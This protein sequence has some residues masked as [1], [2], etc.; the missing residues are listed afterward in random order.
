MPIKHIKLFCYGPITMNHSSPWEDVWITLFVGKR[1]RKTFAPCIISLSAL[2]SDIG[3]QKLL[4]SSQKSW[5]EKELETLQEVQNKL[6]TGYEFLDDYSSLGGCFNIY[7]NADVITKSVAQ[8]IIWKWLCK[9]ELVAFG[10]KP[11]FNWKMPK[12]IITPV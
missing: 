8:E 12:I 10:T 9:Y 7:C 6:Q 4:T 2:E 3:F 1:K 11:R 5:N